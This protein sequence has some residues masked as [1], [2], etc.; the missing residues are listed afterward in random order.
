MYVYVYVYVKEVLV[1]EGGRCLVTERR[2]DMQLMVL[3]CHMSTAEVA[4]LAN[5]EKNPGIK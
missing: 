4:V 3:C 2:A 1:Q 5:S